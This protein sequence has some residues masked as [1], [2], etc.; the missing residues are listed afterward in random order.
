MEDEEYYEVCTCYEIE[1]DDGGLCPCCDE[2][3]DITRADEM[4][5]WIDG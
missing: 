3:N 1:W 5:D 2:E 4:L